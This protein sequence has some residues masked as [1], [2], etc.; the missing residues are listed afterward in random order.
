MIIHAGE[1]P[2]TCQQCGKSFIKKGTLQMHNRIHTG[3]KPFV[4]TQCGLSFTQKGTLNSH[5]RIHTGEKPYT[6]KLC[7]NSFTRKGRLN[8]HMRCL[9]PANSVERV[10]VNKETSRSTSVYTGVGYFSCQ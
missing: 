3:E 4:C 7:G 2:Y 1:K 10:A 6:C 8:T 9:L 5:I